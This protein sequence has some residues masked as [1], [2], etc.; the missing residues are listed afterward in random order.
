MNGEPIRPGR[1][2]NIPRPE[3]TCIRFASAC[4][5]AFFIDL[6]LLAVGQHPQTFGLNRDHGRVFGQTMSV[7]SNRSADRIWNLAL[8]WRLLVDLAQKTVLVTHTGDA[9]RCLCVKCS[10]AFE[11]GLLPIVKRMIVALSAIDALAKERAGS[12]AGKFVH[13]EFVVGQGNGDEVGLWGSC[14][15]PA[16]TDDFF[17]DFGPGHIVLQFAAQ[18]INEAIP[19]IE[20]KDTGFYANDGSG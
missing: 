9:G 11:V 7:A 6:G 8:C 1:S 13:V 3:V 5:F 12:P 18:P 19:P 20:N 15:E 16:A 2:N 17:C 10:Q 4:R 14:C